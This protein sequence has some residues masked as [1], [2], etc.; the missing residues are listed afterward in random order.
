MTVSV[1]KQSLASD[2]PPSGISSQL[3]S[4]WYDAKNDWQKAHDL[5]DGPTD[6]LS[7]RVHAYLHRKEGDIWNADYWYRRAGEK[8]PDTSL[9]EEWEMLVSRILNKA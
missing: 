3:T 2:F 7:A 6:L 5:A 9:E 4:L 8:R 1:F